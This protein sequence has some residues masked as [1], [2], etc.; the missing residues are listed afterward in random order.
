MNRAPADTTN[1]SAHMHPP[2]DE[3]RLISADGPINRRTALIQQRRLEESEA[4]AHPEIQARLLRMQRRNAMGEPLAQ[5]IVFEATHTRQAISGPMIA[6]GVVTACGAVLGVLG[7]IE[8]SV[9]ATVGGLCISL[10]GA[11]SLILLQR[12]HAKKQGL[13]IQPPPLFELT[14]LEAFDRLLD[15]SSAALGDDAIERLTSIKASVV[16]IAQHANGVDE[17]FTHEDRLFLRECLR[18]Y[19]PDTLDAFM[20]VPAN[21]R[22]TQLLD[23]QASAQALLLDQLSSLQQE[24]AL[25][26]KKI[27]RSAAEGLMKQNRFLEAKRSR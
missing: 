6:S 16:H 17:Y 14:I 21:Q 9:V 12:S 23:G 19:I 18:R 3:S 13:T 27:G 5:Q 10:A 20:R 4:P 26:E 24:V 7:L 22:N 2:S 15:E 1:P 25:R 11:I 8:S